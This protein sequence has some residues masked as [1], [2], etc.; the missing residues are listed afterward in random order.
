MAGDQRITATTW[1][2]IHVGL[3]V[4]W[5]LLVVPTLLWWRHSILW[6]A[7]MSLYANIAGHWSA[8]QAAAAD[9]HT[10]QE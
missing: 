5:T 6:V 1:R 10:T 8:G 3:A 7:F 2:R 9:E 4:V